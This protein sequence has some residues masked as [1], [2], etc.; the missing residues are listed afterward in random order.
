[1]TTS[2]F[3]YEDVGLAKRPP[4][5]ADAK[6]D[7]VVVG[8]GIAGMSSA[9]EAARF[10]W[11]VIV[12]DR[13]ETIGGVMTPRTTAHLATELDDYY[14]HLI[15]A[16]GED[17]AR[18]YHES[19]VAAV[20]RIEAICRDEGIDA[21]FARLDGLLVPAEPAHQRDLEEEYAAC[22]ALGVEV[23]WLDEAPV[24]L[25][26]GTRA[27][28]FPN[29]A[30]FHP[31]KYI[32]GLIGA[33]EGRGGRIHGGTVYVDHVEEDGGVTIETEAGHRIRAK[34]AMFATNSPVN[35]KVTIHTKMVPARTYVI[36]G[37]VPKGSVPDLL[38]WDTLDAYHY[39][40]LQPLS[41]AEDLLIVGGEDHRSGTVN[42][43]DERFAHLEAWTRE[44]FPAFREARY[45][46]SGQV[47]EPVDF[48]P[49]SGRNP[50]NRNIYV[51]TGDSGQGMTNG[52]AGAINFAALLFEQKAHFAELFDPSRK[53][54][55]ATSLGE[56]VT[57][58]AEDV[59]N[60][61]EYLTGGEISSVEELEP[62]EGAII[63]RGASK[64]AAFRQD[65]G[66]VIERSA[67]CTHV[68]CIVHWNGLEKC[69]DC[70]CHGSQF[71]PDGQV[72]NGPAIRP[73]AEAG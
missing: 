39:V 64:I 61:S 25:P 37:P 9:Y 40:R 31:L 47:M 32:R 50:G 34:A 7:L 66:T 8:S 45:R 60:L 41:E 43:M 68:G 52:V 51:H 53:P 71:T 49:Y 35:D 65:D 55:A 54:V 44:R 33:V 18:R 30:R 12:I 24:S 3:W 23:E 58:R 15:E 48:M 4:L 67:V 16:V 17:D 26:D 42:D 57:G 72:I 5:D 29:Q 22:R 20:N 36:A 46:W 1:M 56:F 21:D 59:A 2:S 70:P 19:Q 28:R 14:S 6:C 13:A 73:L 38:I 63:R 11:R 62:G 69:W 10:G 27:L